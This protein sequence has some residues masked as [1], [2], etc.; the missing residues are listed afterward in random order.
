[1]SL[2]SNTVTA[3]K[4]WDFDPRSIP[5]CDIWFD[6]SD[7][8]TLGLT[9]D[10]VN[11]WGNKGSISMNAVAASGTVTSGNTENG[12]NYLSFP[13]SSQMNF[14]CAIV[15]QARTWFIVA[16][17]QTQINITGDPSPTLWGPL[18]NVTGLSGTNRIFFSRNW[19][20]TYTAT[21][22]YHSTT[23][24]LQTTTAPNPFATM[25]VISVV[26]SASSTLANGIFINGTSY[27]L[28]TNLNAQSFQEG[29]VTYS[30]N[31]ASYATAS[32]ICEIIHYGRDLTGPDRKAVESY[33]MNKWGIK[34]GNDP[35]FNPA[36]SLTNT[37]LVWYDSDVD[38]NDATSRATSFTFSTGVN[39][40]T[41]KDKSGN[42]R[43]A[44]FA[45]SGVITTRPTLIQNAV[46]PKCA[47][48]FAG[49]AALSN[50]LSL[51]TNQSHTL[52]VVTAPNNTTAT[53]Q[54]VLTINGV[55]GTRP[56]M[57]TIYKSDTNIWWY[58]GGTSPTNGTIASVP[59]VASRYDILAFYW[60]PT[61]RTQLN[62]NGNYVTASS[63]S[64]TTLTLN[65][66]MALGATTNAGAYNEPF[67]GRIAEVLL[68]DG[69]L[70]INQRNRVE[71]YLSLKWNRPIINGIS[72]VHPY[73]KYSHSL[74]PFFP[75]EIPNC[76]LWLDGADNSTFTFSSG[77]NI[78]TWLDKSGNNRTATATGTI[79][80]LGNINGRSCTNWTQTT[81]VAGGGVAT[82]FRGLNNISLTGS[83]MTVFAVFQMNSTSQQNSRVVSLGLN[84]TVDS[85]NT[86]YAAPLL[87]LSNT[88]FQGF[89]NGSRST[90]DFST[91]A[92]IPVVATSQF[93]G[94]NHTLYVNGTGYTP[95][96]STG[97]FNITTYVIGNSMAEFNSVWFNGTIGEVLIFNTSLNLADRQRIEGYLADKWGLRSSFANSHFFTLAKQAIPNVPLTNPL[98]FLDLALWLDAADPDADG[99]L[100]ASGT[101]V[102]TWY[103]K[104][105]NNRHATQATANLRPI[106]SID[107][108]YPSIDFT[109][110]TGTGK[111]LSGTPVMLSLNYGI[112]VVSRLGPNGSIG[113]RSVF[114]VSKSGSNRIYVNT[115]KPGIDYRSSV[116]YNTNL[117]AGTFKSFIGSVSNNN[118]IMLVISDNSATPNSANEVFYTNGTLQTPTIASN[119]GHTNVA[120]DANGYRIGLDFDVATGEAN[121][122]NGF[123]YEVIVMLHLPTRQER[124]MIEGY[125]AR[126]WGLLSSLPDSHMFKKIQP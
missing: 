13:A 106:F 109:V 19:H 39:I 65:G 16:R 85:A 77:N 74:R 57:L 27:V 80:N 38:F 44:T 78:A 29:S 61:P 18:N 110:N 46:G 92:D 76:Q 45:S 90:T 86:N 89:R 75:M 98:S 9:G 123:V 50:T 62:I 60:E 87:R 115:G 64:P 88:S 36:T 59:V 81:N 35:L 103:D 67:N 32:D 104:S 14:T 96:A 100:P 112:F 58:S 72:I 101:S 63:S 47:V 23:V 102:S 2:L 15:N 55:S 33:L 11:T 37:C 79:T 1:M 93:D 3:R 126:K 111:F 107:G 5:E 28:T 120:T 21:L 25:M 94:T 118:P 97:S 108:V 20:T 53:F 73:T 84:G 48:N 114:Y 69:I 124:Q 105:G 68:Y 71:R 26:N 24:R 49:A 113:N 10:V 70:T 52:F 95:V 43:D 12:L 82:Y 17:G 119:N 116:I 121:Y 91:V 4:Y 31:T 117:T 54:S 34:R 125:L 41:W 56:N 42:G 6:A 66:R 122:L 7:T 40:S 30:I 99:I 22:G 83:S 51:A 8:S